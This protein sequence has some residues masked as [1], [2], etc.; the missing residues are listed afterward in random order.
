MTL[1]RNTLLALLLVSFTLSHAAH[2]QASKTEK[3]FLNATLGAQGLYFDA[4]GLDASDPGG[5]ISFRAGWGFSELFTLYLSLNGA[6]MQGDDNPFIEDDYEWG[7]LELGGRFNF[8]SGKPFV[9]FADVAL[10]AVAVVRED[11]DLEYLGAGM[12]IGGG[13]AYYLTPSVALELGLRLGWGGFNEVDQS[14]VALDF[15]TDDFGYA[16][17]RLSFGLVFYPMR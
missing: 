13:A 6:E 8:R 3:L 11:I 14:T 17:S 5:S 9:P 4:D 15:D 10:R 12:T 1:F 7:A 16:E 2:G